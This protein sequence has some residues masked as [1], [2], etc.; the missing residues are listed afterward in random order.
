[1]GDD[2][3]AADVSGASKSLNV[4]A[5]QDKMPDCFAFEDDK[6][7]ACRKCKVATL[8]RQSREANRPECF[9]KYFEPHSEECKVC[10][11]A[12]FCVLAMPKTAKKIA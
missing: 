5:T 12:A 1:M 4:S 10:I 8:C 11:E 2:N 3:T 7:P 6:D 9:G